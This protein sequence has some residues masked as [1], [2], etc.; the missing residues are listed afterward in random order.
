MA[1]SLAALMAAALLA[2]PACNRTP[3]APARAPEPG[4]DAGTVVAETEPP[5]LDLMADGFV[6][7]RTPCRFRIDP[8]LHRL[9][10]RRSG[11]LPWQE[12]VLVEAGQEARVSASMVGS[13]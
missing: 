6:R 13:H 4:P 1:R 9:S 10:V 5:G 8:G 11:Y 3:A 7:C 2:G 12:D